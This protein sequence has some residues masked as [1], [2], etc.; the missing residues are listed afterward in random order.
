VPEALETLQQIATA[1]DSN[2]LNPLYNDTDGPSLAF[3]TG[4]LAQPSCRAWYLHREHHPVAAVW[5][6]CYSDSAEIIDLRV[7]EDERRA[8]VATRLLRASFDALDG[9]DKVTLEVRAGN[10]AAR[11]LYERMGFHTVGNRADYYATSQGR[12]DALLMSILRHETR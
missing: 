7:R 4:L 1:S 9:V 11:A 5:Y 3:L 8:G 10:T 12:E 6:Q 2:M